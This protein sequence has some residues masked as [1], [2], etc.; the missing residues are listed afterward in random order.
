MD[1]VFSI[2]RKAMKKDLFLLIAIFVV[3]LLTVF[4]W[5]GF[6][7]FFFINTLPLATPILFP[8]FSALLFSLGLVYTNINVAKELHQIKSHRSVFQWTI[9]FQLWIVGIAFV[10]IFVGYIILF[11]I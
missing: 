5:L 1:E 6:P 7:L 9:Y 11:Y 3:S 2:Y 8:F 4:L 10:L